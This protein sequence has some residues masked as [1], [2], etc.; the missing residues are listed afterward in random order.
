VVLSTFVRAL[1]DLGAYFGVSVA[2][3]SLTMILFFSAGMVLGHRVLSPGMIK[4]V[5][6]GGVPVL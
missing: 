4:G 6:G 5:V 1:L 3:T 2:L